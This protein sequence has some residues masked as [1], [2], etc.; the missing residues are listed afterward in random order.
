MKTFVKILDTI[1]KVPFR[2]ALFLIKA[3]VALVVFFVS[4]G[5]RH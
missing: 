4:E 5:A 1:L 3:C 2:I